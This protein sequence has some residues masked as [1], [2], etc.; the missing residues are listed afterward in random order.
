MPDLEREL[1][2]L[3][4]RLDFPPT[5]DLAQGVRDRLAE[6]RGW[7]ALLGRRALVVALAVLTLA[8]VAALAV[9]PARTAIL[10]WLG[11]EGARIVRVEELPPTAVPRELRLGEPVTLAEARARAG[12]A[13]L[14]PLAESFAR[15]DAVYFSPSVPGGAVTLRYGSPTAIRALLTQFQSDPGF[16]YIRKSAAPGTRIEQ[17][18]VGGSRGYWLEGK[19]HLVVFRNQRGEV[20]TGTL[21]L[22]ANTLLWQRGTTTLRLEGKLTKE[23]AIAIAES[24]RASERD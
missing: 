1:R 3:G 19:P 17:V 16:P 4:V 7:R 11:I 21:R 18:S 2:D 5:P 9:P 20:Q 15:P 14:V 12:F 13:V 10:R 22:A 23:Q 6:P 24:V 8:V